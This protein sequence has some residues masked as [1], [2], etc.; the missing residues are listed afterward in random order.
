VKHIHVINYGVD[1]NIYRLGKVKSSHPHVFYLGRLKRF[2]GVHL[3]IKAMAEVVKEIPD[4]RLSI[5]GTGDPDY[6][7]ELVELSAKLNLTKNI[8]FCE[9]GLHDSIEQKVQ[10]MQ[11]AWVLVFP[12]S[13]EGFGLVVVEANACGT[14]TIAT[15]VPGLR[16][17]VLDANT[18]F[19]VSRDA[20][21]LAESIKRMLQDKELREKLS[22]NAFEWSNQFDWD[23]T[24]EKMLKVLE[25]ISR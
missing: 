9:F 7:R 22:K 17:T 18:G 24:A 4:A 3:L 15:N 19:L 5:V 20:D 6:K 8:V 21:S 16:E 11:E 1:H 13:R 2:K 23:R 14:P 25:T 10:I 12:S